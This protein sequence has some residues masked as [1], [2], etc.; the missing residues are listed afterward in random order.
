MLL[1]SKYRSI[2]D[3]LSSQRRETEPTLRPTESV[4]DYLLQPTRD[5]D[6]Y[7]RLVRES[8]HILE[9]G[10]HQKLHAKKELV[11][12]VNR[13]NGQKVFLHFDYQQ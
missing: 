13:K 4:E 6:N 9:L 11:P 7:Q 8:N 1:K 2:F 5:H 12:Y 3:T 10:A